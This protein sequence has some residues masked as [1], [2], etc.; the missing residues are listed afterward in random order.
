MK[1]D[2]KKSDL[3]TTTDTLSNNFESNY[4]LFQLR[5]LQDAM[6]CLFSPIRSRL[7]A[8]HYVMK[9]H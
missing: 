7:I 5:S 3:I 4:I 9:K 8:K 1:K 6:Q 2:K